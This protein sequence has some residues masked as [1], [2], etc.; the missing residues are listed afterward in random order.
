MEAKK[1]EKVKYLTTLE[2]A[3]AISDPFRYKILSCFNKM[4]GSATVKQIADAMGEVPAKVHYHVKKLEK[5]GILHLV[6][7]EEINGIIA[8]YYEPTAE[9]F[10]IKLSDEYAKLQ[11]N[12][13]KLMMSEI[14][15]M[16]S[17]LYD[18][19][20]NQILMNLNEYADAHKKG[21]ASLS[22]QNL[23]ITEE[24]AKIFSQYVFNFFNE[25]KKPQKNKS[26]LKKYHTFFSIT[27]MIDKNEDKK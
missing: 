10:E 16:I 9:D 8:K 25:H 21:D 22:M 19:S 17:K 13:A 15:K 12:N 27:K 23:Y 24:E 26:N 6:R 5:A 2:E 20:K 14:Q 4:N 1:V 18:T 7:T 11:E 3:K